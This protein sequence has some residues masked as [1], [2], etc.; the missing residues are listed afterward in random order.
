MRQ[1]LF[2][3]LFVAASETVDPSPPDAGAP[4]AAITT[5]SGPPPACPP[6]WHPAGGTCLPDVDAGTQ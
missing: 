3:L 2:V 4:D 5:P 6:G 1:I